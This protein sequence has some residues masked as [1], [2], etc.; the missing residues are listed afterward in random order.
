MARVLVVDDDGIVLKA[1]GC[2]VRRIGHE[3]E[4]T[5]G[6]LAREVGALLVA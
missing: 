2:M 5:F 1:V 3:G 6:E 4:G